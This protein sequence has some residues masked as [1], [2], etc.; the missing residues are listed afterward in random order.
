MADVWE[1]R[2]V[3]KNEAIYMW[4]KNKK[5]LLEIISPPAQK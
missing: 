2:G 4:K 5:L 1:E 3:K